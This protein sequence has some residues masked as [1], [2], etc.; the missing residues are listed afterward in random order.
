MTNKEAE[1]A[2]LAAV[3][4][5][6]FRARSRKEVM[7]KLAEKDFD[8]ETIRAAVVMLE[9]ARYIDDVNYARQFIENM[10]RK[11]YGKK[12]TDYRLSQK[13]VSRDDIAAAYAILDELS[14]EDSD[15]QLEAATRAYEKWA[16]NREP[17]RQKAFAFLV[18]RG[19]SAG[20]INK[21][22]AF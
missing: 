7:D 6:G 1:R 17:D 10:S 13:G 16:R 12:M 15:A 11:N 2:Y 22:L 8:E 9:D 4:L 14:E 20:V 19:F 3:R 5:L 21:I 18:R